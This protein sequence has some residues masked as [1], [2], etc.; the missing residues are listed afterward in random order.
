VSDG[1]AE[2]HA[3]ELPLDKSVVTFGE[4]RSKR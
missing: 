4:D 3:R 1:P 2:L